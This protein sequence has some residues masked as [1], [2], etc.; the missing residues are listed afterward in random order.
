MATFTLYISGDTQTMMRTTLNVSNR[1]APVLL[2]AIVK[3]AP[4]TLL[5]LSFG[6]TGHA[7]LRIR[8]PTD[9]RPPLAGGEPSVA[10]DLSVFGVKKNNAPAPTGT[11]HPPLMN[12]IRK[13]Q[14]T[15]MVGEIGKT[16]SFLPLP[17]PAPLTCRP[18]PLLS[19]GRR[20]GPGAGRPVQGVHRRAALPHE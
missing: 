8:R 20:V 3:L 16:A 12:G 17:L 9:Y 2:L 18:S 10:L 14:H 5:P 19:G 6:E 4:L 11:T 1:T 13:R 7:P 15:S